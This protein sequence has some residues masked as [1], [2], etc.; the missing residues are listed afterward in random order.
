M[1]TLPATDGIRQMNF[2]PVAEIFPLIEGDEFGKLVEDIRANGLIEPI[3]IHPDGS[4]IDGRNRYRAC[5]QV[6]IDPTTR[7]WDGE[8]SLLDFVLSMNLHRRHLNQSQLACVAVLSLA[9]REAEADAKE[10]QL[11]QLK[12]GDEIPVKAFVPEREMGQSRDKVA[13]SF[14]VSPRY[15]SDAKKLQQDHPVL[16]DNVRAGEKTITEAKAEIKAAKKAETV[17]QIAKEP[18]P[19]PTG[20][21]RVIVI[22]PPWKYESRSEDITHRARNP[23]PDMDIEAIKALPVSALAHEDCILWLWTT[24]AFLREAFECLD[25]WGFENKTVLTWVKD[26]MGLGNWLRGQTEHCLMA[27]KGKP[28]VTLTNQ[29]TALSAPLREH[30]R[31]PDE[32]YAL[33]ESLCPGNRLEMFARQSRDGWQS[34]GAEHELF[35]AA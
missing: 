2:N 6:G 23:Y 14:E 4:I 20:P 10:R 28:I 1:S 24:N 12:R 13:K 26:R 31:K 7:V 8:G 32:F 17:E 18:A 27:V 30:S 22:D 5:V 34:C 11:A 21:F 16:F 25:A 33:V 35:D 9:F 15:V 19:F 3:W 29:T